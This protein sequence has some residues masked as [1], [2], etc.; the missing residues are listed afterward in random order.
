MIENSKIDFYLRNRALIE[1]WSEIGTAAQGL[2]Q[3]AIL[4]A[5]TRPAEDGTTLKIENDSLARL[6]VTSDPLPE[7]WIGLTWNPK[8]L[9]RGVGGWPTLVLS[10]D[11][12]YPIDL[13]NGVKNVTV[14]AVRRYGLTSAG[15]S[16]WLRWGPV[17]PAAEPIDIDAYSEYCAKRLRDAWAE[18]HGAIE[19]VLRTYKAP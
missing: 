8:G 13:R 12:K 14:T 11:G 4:S 7:S 16:G 9:L 10:V 19:T 6:W 1:E 3:T 18:F 5:L 17:V 2:L 15:A